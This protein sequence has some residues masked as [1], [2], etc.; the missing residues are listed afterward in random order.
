MGSFGSVFLGEWRGEDVILKQANRSVENAEDLLVLELLLNERAAK[1]APR[2]CADFLGAARVDGASAG[3]VY[4][5]KLQEGLWLAW[6]YQ[7]AAGHCDVSPAPAPQP[8]Q[9]PSQ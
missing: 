4:N 3:N 5:G 9:Q 6:R 1:L 7:G 2:A 8:C